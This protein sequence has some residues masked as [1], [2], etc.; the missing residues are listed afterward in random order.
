MI[1]QAAVDLM[2]RRMARFGTSTSLDDDILI[3]L[4]QAQTRLELSP[5]LPWFLLSERSSIGTVANEPRIIVPVDMLREYEE[6]A[7]WVL[8]ASG[9]EHELKKKFWEDIKSDSRFDTPGLPSRYA[10]VGE[11][12]RLRPVPNAIYTVRMIYYKRQDAIVVGLENNWLKWVPD[13]LIAEAGVIVASN[14]LKNKEAA[15]MFQNMITVESRRLLVAS[16]AR[17]QA[18]H[19]MVGED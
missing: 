16:E 5:E 4:N 14:Y 1:G 8:D 6:G 19:P 10:T 9:T 12:F 15:E 17:E 13:L 7:L 3:E 18:N 11:Y 2:K